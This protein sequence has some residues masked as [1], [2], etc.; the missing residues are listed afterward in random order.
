MYTQPHI[1]Q[2]I[3]LGLKWPWHQA[4]LCQAPSD[5]KFNEGRSYSYTPIYAFISRA[6]SILQ[7]FKT[8][9]K[10]TEM[11]DRYCTHCDANKH[12]N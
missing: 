9:C 5:N 4:D 10:K 7:Q 1:Q 6:W 3:S 2:E 12:Y 11:M 8:D